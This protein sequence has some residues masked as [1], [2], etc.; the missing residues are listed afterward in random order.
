MFTTK[1][2]NNLIGV[3]F[4]H[5]RA[6]HVGQL[7]RPEIWTTREGKIDTKRVAVQAVTYVFFNDT[8]TGVAFCSYADQFN[9]EVGR[10][11]ALKNAL[12][13]V[14]KRSGKNDRIVA[15][16][17]AQ[18]W[19]DYFRASTMKQRCNPLVMGR[20][21]HRMANDPRPGHLVTFG[22]GGNGFT[23][24]PPLSDHDAPRLPWA[25]SQPM[26]GE[27]IEHLNNQDQKETR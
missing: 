27:V 6:A 13:T 3:V 16:E 24:A 7:T 4:Q 11:I 21:L 19:E 2:D 8:C 9:R 22:E 15:E 23:N 25:L 12:N 17:R 18:V 1:I 14:L 20:S 26:T 10:R 5:Q